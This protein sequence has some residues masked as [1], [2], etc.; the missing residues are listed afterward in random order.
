MTRPCLASTHD[1][2]INESVVLGL[3]VVSDFATSS[4][5]TA[6]HTYLIMLN[7]N[8]HHKLF[9]SCAFASPM[10]A[11]F[12]GNQEERNIRSNAF[13]EAG[14]RLFRTTTYRRFW[15]VRPLTNTSLTGCYQLLGDSN[16]PRVYDFP[17]R[18]FQCTQSIW[19]SFWPLVK[20]L[21]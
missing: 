19:F 12:K 16:A 6:L 21:S 13:W 4:S 18:G 1:L 14:C 17:T 20:A 9:Q 8:W 7:I 2:F 11:Y 3:W 5:F 15:L 10:A